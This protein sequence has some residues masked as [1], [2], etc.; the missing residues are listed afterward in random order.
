MRGQQRHAA[1]LG[2][3]F[4][5]SL[6]RFGDQHAPRQPGGARRCR[7]RQPGQD[8]GGVAHRHRP[9]LAQESDGQRQVAAGPRQRRHREF[10]PGLGAEGQGIHELRRRCRR[11]RRQ[12]PDQWRHHPAFD[13]HAALGR[14]ARQP[15]GDLGAAAHQLVGQPHRLAFQIVQQ[16]QVD[17]VD[18]A[19]LLLGLEQC[20]AA[21]VQH[22]G[23][24]V[25]G[26]P[27]GAAGQR[28]GQ[29]APPFGGMHHVGRQPRHRLVDRDADAQ[30]AV[31]DDQGE[32]DASPV[33]SPGQRQV[34]RVSLG[35]H[36]H[37]RGAVA[38]LDQRIQQRLGPE[39]QQ[40]VLAGHR[41]EIRRTMPGNDHGM[42]A[43]T[44]YRCGK[45]GLAPPLIE[46]EKAWILVAHAPGPS[47]VSG[48]SSRRA[49]SPASIQ[50]RAAAVSP[51][52]SSTLV[53]SSA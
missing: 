48:S 9:R 19:R 10:Q 8:R 3:V 22:H 47:A 49:G 33:Q 45:I 52:I 16:Q 46:R 34:G 12:L 51:R 35:A 15:G 28:G 5:G 32:V 20:G 36:Y 53:S 25:M 2:Q 43:V 18:E 29:Q 30:R 14:A 13:R 40:A 38:G 1:R 41:A 6:G 37:Q 17:V 21:G 23:G 42:L 50:P 11:H 31:A 7:R 44:L 4:H 39:A 24:V 27:R 26:E